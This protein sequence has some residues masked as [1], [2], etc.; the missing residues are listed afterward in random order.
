[1]AEKKKS[2]GGGIWIFL[3][4]VLLV[5]AGALIRFNVGNITEKYLRKSLE[6]VPVVKNILPPK[7]EDSEKYE[8]YS[9]SEFISE[10]KSLEAQKISLETKNKELEETKKS[11]SDELVILR[12]FEKQQTEFEARKREFDRAVL[13]KS[14]IDFKIYYEKAYPDIAKEIYATV[15]VNDVANEKIKKMSAMYADMEAGAAATI[16]TEMYRS[17]ADL[18]IAILNNLDGET[19]GLILASMDYKTA[20]KITKRM[21]P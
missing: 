8:Y 4:L 7:P 13:E 12:K 16:L 9:K 17:D 5:G 18:A 3:F 20:A 14:E 6:T 15:A 21:A 11:M 2:S 10:I 19:S 1:M